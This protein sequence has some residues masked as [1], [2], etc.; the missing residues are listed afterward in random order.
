[1]ASG[2]KA[3][4]GK[5]VEQGFVDDNAASEL[6]SVLIAAAKRPAIIRPVNAGR[7]LFGNEFEENFIAVV[8]A[9]W[10]L[11]SHR[12][13]MHTGPARPKGITRTEALQITR[14]IPMLYV[15]FFRLPQASRRWTMR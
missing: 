9:Q 5:D 8:D 2:R 11:C 1:M 6:L 15:H 7:Y 12:C 13:K 4:F 14:W 3:S 10:L